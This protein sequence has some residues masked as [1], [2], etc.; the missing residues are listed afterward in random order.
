MA[1]ILVVEDDKHTRMLTVAR[2][3]PHYM[4]LEAE[5][6]ERHWIFFIISMLI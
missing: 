6:G 1:T 5:D 2:L 3:K 4:V